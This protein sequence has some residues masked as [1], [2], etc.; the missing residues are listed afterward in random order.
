MKICYF[1]IY[2]PNFGRNKTYISGLIQNGVEVIECRDTS[3]GPVKFFRLWKKHQKIIKQ[4]GYDI[5][6]V[7]YP[8]H[9]VVPF[10]KMISKKP[11]IF[12]ALSTLFE[13]EVISRGKYRFNLFMKICIMLIDYL[14]V[15]SADLILV[16]T[17]TQKMFFVKRF[18]L[19]PDRVLRVYTGTDEEA[20]FPERG[21]VKREKFTAVF[22]GRFLPE[23]GITHIIRAAKLLEDSDINVLIIGGGHMEKEIKSLVDTLKP[24]NVEWVRDYLPADILRRRLLECH[25]ALGQFEKHERL[26]RTIPHKAFEALALGLPYVTGRT[27]GISEL[28]KDGKDCLMVNPGD[29]SDLAFKLMRLKSDPDLAARLGATGYRLFEHRLTAKILAQ[30]IIAHLPLPHKY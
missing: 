15:K 18:S 24:C 9:L 2:D 14:A 30:E 16:E 8:G 13:G 28:L 1:G 10:A 12:D 20:N 29:S 27:A 19:R 11:V 4:G 7:G 5:L 21:I 23:A 3:A 25:V 26:S 6:L 22:R 17:E